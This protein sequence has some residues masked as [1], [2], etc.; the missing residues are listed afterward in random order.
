M[1]LNEFTTQ[2]SNCR[3]TRIDL[4]L[5]HYYYGDGEFYVSLTH[6]LDIG[7]PFP[8]G[9]RQYLRR[10][11]EEES[12]ELLTMTKD[13]GTKLHRA[14]EHLTSG[15]ELYLEDYPT[16]YEKDALVSYIRTLRFL[17]PDNRLPKD[18]R[19]ELLVADSK[20]KVG[21]TLD[22]KSTADKRRLDALLAG[23]TALKLENDELVFKKPLIGRKRLVRFVL[24]YKFT[25]RSAYN[26]KVQATKYRQ[27]NNLSY[28][29]EPKANYAYIWRYSPKH[30]LHFDM[31]DASL[32]RQKKVTPAA[33]NRI[34]TTALEY[35]GGFP[36]PPELVVF[37]DSVRLFGQ[38]TKKGKQD[39][40]PI[41]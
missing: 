19:T 14:L 15:L 11:S 36:E 35:L 38:V 9:L 5:E 8:E 7:A 13:R 29:K 1:G 34:Y 17:F 3:L 37:P 10:S 30:K 23:S 2:L 25:G 33:F 26:H 28:T 40:R 24:D 31:Q 12:L 32:H 41:A 16:V 6:I 20:R 4:D 39:V 22:I 18:T 27:M 21:G